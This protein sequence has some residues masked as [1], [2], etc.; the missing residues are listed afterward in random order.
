MWNPGG[1]AHQNQ[2]AARV[3]CRD[4][5]GLLYAPAS[6]RWLTW[7][8][9]MFTAIAV[10]S[11]VLSATSLVRALRLNQNVHSTSFWH[12]ASNYRRNEKL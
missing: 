5:E 11:G 7:L 6:L 10:F 12:D 8:M 3:V 9:L 4:V 2:V 1:Y